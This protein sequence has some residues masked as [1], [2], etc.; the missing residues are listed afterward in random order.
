ME[1]F[2]G[3]YRVIWKVTHRNA[4][5]VLFVSKYYSYEYRNCY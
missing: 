1:A 3:K 2:K 4:N 5:M